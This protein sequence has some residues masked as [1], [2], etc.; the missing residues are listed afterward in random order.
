M[1][2]RIVSFLLLFHLSRQVLANDAASAIVTCA[3]RSSMFALTWLPSVLFLIFGDQPP[4]S[5]ACDNKILI[6]QYHYPNVITFFSEPLQY[7][8]RETHVL[9]GSK[10]MS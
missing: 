1:Y 3:Y 9:L 6:N 2:W 5:S 8:L 7:A 10:C 4:V